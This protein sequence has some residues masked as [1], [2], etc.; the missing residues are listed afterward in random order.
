MIKYIGILKIGMVEILVFGCKNKEERK[1]AREKIKKFLS[2]KRSDSEIQFD[3][4][5]IEQWLK[6]FYKLTDHSLMEVLE[7]ATE[8][9]EPVRLRLPDEFSEQEMIAIIGRETYEVLIFHTHDGGHVTVGKDGIYTEYR[10]K[11]GLEIE[12]ESLQMIGKHNRLEVDYESG[13]ITCFFP[14]SRLI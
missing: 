1:M 12:K 7:I 10:V 9:D 8:T 3:E 6:E 5:Q 11:S 13:E 14:K 4:D 2:Q